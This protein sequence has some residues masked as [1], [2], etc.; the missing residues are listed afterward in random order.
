MADTAMIPWS[1][2]VLEGAQ[3]VQPA[4]AFSPL[5]D[6]AQAI[7][8]IKAKQAELQRARDAEQATLAASAAAQRPKIE[9]AQTALA[10]PMPTPPTAPPLTE[11]P[12]RGLTPFLAPIDGEP[13]ETSI[14]KLLQGI[15]LLATGISGFAR[16]DGRAALAS[17]RG[18]LTGWQAG[19][20]IRAD[21]HFADWKAATDAMLAKWDVEHKTYKDLMEQRG[22]SVEELLTDAKLEALKQG[23]ETA[24]AAFATGSVEKALNFL[25]QQQTHGDA[26]MLKTAQ[27]AAADASRKTPGAIRLQGL[28]M[29]REG[30]AQRERDVARR[31]REETFYHDLLTRFGFG[32]PAPTGT[33]TPSGAVMEPPTVSVGK[34]GIG[35][36][37]EPR[38]LGEQEKTALKTYDA[39]LATVNELNEFKAPEIAQ[40]VGLMN[41]PVQEAKRWIPGLASDR[42]E[43]FRSIVMRL[44]SSAFGE[45]G[46]QLTPF[47]YG[48]VSGFTPTGDEPSIEAF[49]QKVGGLRRFTTI[50]RNLVA[51]YSR[52]GIDASQVPETQW[53]QAMKLGLGSV[54]TG[55]TAGPTVP[56]RWERGPD[57]TLRRIP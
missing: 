25:T 34:G 40:Y 22:K 6:V 9:A 53:D 30:T 46:K 41:R 38:K 5:T 16:G 35:L 55:P 57:G 33:A 4:Q 45:G 51:Y 19:D 50:R 8:Q 44:K 42:Y 54:P 7:P 43:H 21:R 24:V 36:Q 23:N 10:Q 2:E 26:V 17:M 49:L 47:E 31:E 52:Q 1:P 27:L 18:A 3:P 48:V 20:T 56:E 14:A 13:A 29:Q 39:I 37:F 12:S 15:G 28:D 32:G 11:P